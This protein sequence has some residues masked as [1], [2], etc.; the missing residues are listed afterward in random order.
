MIRYEEHPEQGY[1]EIILDGKVDRESFG[2]V[3][4]RMG[5]LMDE[6]GKIGLMKRIV[7]FGGIEPSALWDD[8]KFAYRHLKHIGPVA[9]VSDKRW[10][11]VWTKLAQPFWSS[12]VHFFGEDEL[13]EA[14][15]WLSEHSPSSAKHGSIRAD[16]AL[17]VGQDVANPARKPDP[18]FERIWQTTDLV[19]AMG[20]HAL[21]RE[22][23]LHV[24][25]VE[26]NSHM[27]AGGGQSEFAI[28]VRDDD[29]ERARELLGSGGFLRDPVAQPA[30]SEIGQAGRP[31]RFRERRARTFA[32]VLSLIPAALTVQF[33]T[34]IAPD[35]P[36][37]LADRLQV[38]AW[39]VSGPLA[40]CLSLS[41]G[42]V[43][44]SLL[45][46]SYFAVLWRSKLGLVFPGVH[47]VGAALWCLAA[48]PMLGLRVT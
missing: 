48:L 8:M 34:S 33:A 31:E 35:S 4:R 24:L 44:A 11:E 43:V 36:A 39:S 6:R 38:A 32:T 30:L 47:L 23:G 27:I 40:W 21:L 1:V 15:A 14:H 2:V 12:D 18:T 45:W 17:I 9:V 46:G 28:E 16:G 22:A 7:S 19:R 42:A 3:A 29:S 37:S 25:P 20:A 5:T 26:S 13:E 10:I 41:A